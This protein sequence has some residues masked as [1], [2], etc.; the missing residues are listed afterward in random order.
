[1]LVSHTSKN[2]DTDVIVSPKQILL[3]VLLFFTAFLLSTGGCA[4]WKLRRNPAYSGPKIP[5]PLPVRACDRHF[6]ID[7]ISA[8]LSQY[9]R[10]KSEQRLRLTDS[11]LTEGWIETHP[12]I[13]S[14]ILE[15]W[16]KD[17]TP[18]YEKRFASLQT[19][20]RRAKVRVTPDGQGYLV[21]VQVL[22]ELEDKS[23]PDHSVVSGS[24]YRYDGSLDANHGQESSLN[25]D[26]YSNLKW[27]Q[28]GRDSGLEQLILRNIQARLAK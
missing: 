16:R 26:D 17:S 9:F 6:V 18:G 8:E 15:P 12:E 28:I 25:I 5:N 23:P 14:G 7:Q 20:R 13:G 27:I 19:V 21:E 3:P 2:F 10:V 1:M 11:I 24:S 4:T 22:R